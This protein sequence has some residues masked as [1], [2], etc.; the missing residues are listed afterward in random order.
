MGKIIVIAGDLATGKSTLARIIGRRYSLPVFIKDE[1]KEILADTV[2]FATRDENLRLSRAAVETMLYALRVSAP[3]VNG[4]VLEANFRS[5]ELR[6]IS[7]MAAD[8]GCGVLLLRLTG[9]TDTLYLRF[10]NRITKENRHPAH[11]SAG[12]TDPDAF[13]EYVLSRRPED[14]GMECIDLSADTFDYQTDPALFRRLD[15]FFG[16]KS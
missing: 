3:N 12:L 16:V 13:R 9:S 14:C 7:N 5:S 1:V 8:A 15:G 11:L 6:A 10:M 2:G 4:M